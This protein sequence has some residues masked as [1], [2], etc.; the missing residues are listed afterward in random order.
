M[1]L[2]R[3]LY[4][5]NFNSTR[6]MEWNNTAVIISIYKLQIYKETP[7]VVVNFTIDCQLFSYQ[8]VCQW[9][10]QDQWQ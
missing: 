10:N 3:F 2:Y 9:F 5:G 4:N 1:L 8:S 7:S 6:V